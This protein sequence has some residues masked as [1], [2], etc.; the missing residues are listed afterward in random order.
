MISVFHLIEYIMNGCI[1]CFNA[2]Y[3]NL[4]S[5][6]N[7]SRFAHQSIVSNRTFPS[8]SSLLHFICIICIA[9]T[10]LTTYVTFQIHMYVIDTDV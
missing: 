10:A 6:E 7:T 1:L 3:R 4:P 5:A 2:F 9:Y 8:C